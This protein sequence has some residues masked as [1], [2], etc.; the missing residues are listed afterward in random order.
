MA[1]QTTTQQLINTIVETLNLLVETARTE[2]QENIVSLFTSRASAP[3][4]GKPG[5]KPGRKAVRTAAPKPVKR[6][7][8]PKRSEDE[9]NATI[10]R[11]STFLTKHPNSS[12]KQIQQATGLTAAELQFPFRKMKEAKMLRSKGEGVNTTYSVRAAAAASEA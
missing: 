8:Q 12:S 9:I 11:M 1:Q 6:T 10:K 2:E 7:K 3:K 4:K 5:P